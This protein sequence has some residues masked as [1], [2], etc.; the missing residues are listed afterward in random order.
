M[1]IIIAINQDY[2]YLVDLYDI[3]VHNW[4]TQISKIMS[5]GYM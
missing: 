3:N 5:Y 4:D 1:I 2:G